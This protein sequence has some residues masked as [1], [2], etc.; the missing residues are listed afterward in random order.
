MFIGPT[1]YICFQFSGHIQYTLLVLYLF[2]NPPMVYYLLRFVSGGTYRLNPSKHG[3]NP[4]SKLNLF[5]YGPRTFE[6]PQISF[7]WHDDTNMQVAVDCHFR[8]NFVYLVE[9]SLY[10]LEEPGESDDGLK[11]TAPN[12]PLSVFPEYCKSMS[13]SPSSSRKLGDLYASYA[14]DNSM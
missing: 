14:T 4:S 11:L 1:K 10:D 5:T 9:T 8:M 6:V 2:L 13:S 7:R 3:P 12:A